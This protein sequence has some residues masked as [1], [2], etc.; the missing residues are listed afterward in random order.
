MK[1]LALVLILAAAASAQ[2]SVPP[3]DPNDP[4]VISA[5]MLQLVESTAILSPDLSKAL[6]PLKPVFTQSVTA[7]RQTPRNPAVVYQFINEVKAWLALAD[8]M[9]RPNPF[10]AEAARQYTEL[11]DDLDRM[12]QHFTAILQTQNTAAQRRDADP[13]DLQH[14]AAEDA[15]LGPPAAKVP[16]VVFLGDSITDRWRLNEYFTGR[17]FV[18]RG[19]AGQNTLQLLARFRQDVV[20]LS[21]KAV[22]ILGGIN[23]IGEGLSINQIEQDIMEMVDIAKAHNIKP[24]LCSVLP[25]SDYHRGDNPDYEQ[26]KLRPPAT[27]QAINT[28]VQGYA[29]AEG[30]TYLDYYM[31]TVDSSG[32]LQYDLS[33]DGLH[34]NA[35]G[36]RVMSPLVLQAIG[37]ALSGDDSAGRRRLPFLSK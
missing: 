14:Y 17:D 10:P 8:S 35:K 13:N 36:Y 26:T 31:S 21:P 11:R 18:N 16:R 24:V 34:P 29:K 5:R 7:I 22:V 6:D 32:M 25:V 12:Q 20:A 15:K 37:A 1:Q 19:I 33:D 3:P 9:P 23:D 4:A 28:W 30:L 2:I 27:I